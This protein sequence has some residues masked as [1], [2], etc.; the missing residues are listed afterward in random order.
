M[1]L[2][3]YAPL[4]TPVVITRTDIGII[5]RVDADGKPVQ[6]FEIMLAKKNMLIVRPIGARKASQPVKMELPVTWDVN[7]HE[8]DG[9]QFRFMKKNSVEIGPKSGKIKRVGKK[10][11]GPT[12]LDT[13]RGIW[14]ANPNLTRKDMLQKFVDEGKCTVQGANTYYLSIKKENE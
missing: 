13:C 1:D 9:E 4:E 2:Q 14:K 5:A 10:S 3:N 12:K 7:G 6:T 8:V 11:E